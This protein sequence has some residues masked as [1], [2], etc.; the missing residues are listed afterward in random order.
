M[1]YGATA[2]NVR[3]CLPSACEMRVTSMRADPR[4]PERLPATRRLGSS[5]SEPGSRTRR[6]RGAPHGA[7]DPQA[8]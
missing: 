7:C 5:G 4:D 3:R 2:E 6:S 1:L 8:P